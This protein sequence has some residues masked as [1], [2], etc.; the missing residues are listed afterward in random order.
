MVAPT[1]STPSFPFS[2]DLHR[3]R[4]TVPVPA[5]LKPAGKLEVILAAREVSAPTA[6]HEQAVRRQRTDHEGMLAVEHCQ[7]TQPGRAIGREVHHDRLVR[8]A[9]KD[10]AGEGR[11]ADPVADAN[12]GAVEVELATVVARSV[13]ALHHEPQVAEGLIRLQVARPSH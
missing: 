8:R 7:E 13:V 9:R 2:G 3:E 4:E 12:D 1:H 10:L 11:L 6:G 5:G